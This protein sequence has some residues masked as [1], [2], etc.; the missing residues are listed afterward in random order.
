MAFSGLEALL[1]DLHEIASDKRMAFQGR[2]KNLLKIGMLQAARKGR[3]KAATYGAGDLVEMAL[4][5]ELIQIG[6]PPERAWQL[7][8]EN[9]QHMFAS[10]QR[11]V[12]ALRE[13]GEVVFLFFAQTALGQL[14]N[15][16]SDE[17]NPP[18]EVGGAAYIQRVIKKRRRL[19]LLN[20]TELIME[21]ASRF[22]PEHRDE[23]YHDL[24][25]WA[26]VGLYGFPGHE[27]RSIWEDI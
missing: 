6:L 4:A 12:E 1:A 27:V 9:R 20:V 23:L 5:L 14:S 2:L 24:H 26:R 22:Q 25:L 21:I 15:R 17:S 3:G 8:L 10:T 7:L 11:S 18:V 19:S 13:N 16:P